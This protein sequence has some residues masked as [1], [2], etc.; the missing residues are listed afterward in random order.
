MLLVQEYLSSGKSLEDLSNELGLNIKHHPVDP[1]VII[2]YDQ[3]RSPR[4]DPIVRE[5]RGLV[6]EKDTWKVV[7]RS[8][9]RFYNWGE[10]PEEEH[11]FDWKNAT[12]DEKIDGSMIILYHYNGTWR[13]NTRFS[14]ADSIVGDG[15]YTWTQLFEIAMGKTLQEVGDILI[16][17][18]NRSY[19]F[20]L[21]SPYNKVVRWYP[22]PKLYLL[23][24]FRLDVDHDEYH[25][26]G[27]AL[28]AA[29][30]DVD[31]PN[32]YILNNIRAIKKYLRELE[33]NDPTNEGVVINDGIHYWK[34]K[35]EKYLVL[36]KMRGDSGNLYHPKYLVPFILTGETYELLTYFPEVEDKLLEY[37]ARID[38]EY[39]LLQKVWADACGIRSRKDF[40][41]AIKD[42]TRFN[43]LLFSL[44]N[45][46]DVILFPEEEL[47][48]SMDRLDEMWRN[49]LDLILKVLFAKEVVHV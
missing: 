8:F 48:D 15:P 36:H 19:V 3:I 32:R 43:S 39:D 6:L 14:W 47:G 2:D 1:L 10:F 26:A 31:R 34:L 44:R 9:N 20:E 23:G 5:C 38:K 30:L 29:F 25:D 41:L 4:K 33:A 7:A 42:A 28:H 17:E 21:V 46:T 49:S 40:A 37:K 45:E 11:L 18:N 35:N 12:C 22:K 13:V 16:A 24:E 27:L